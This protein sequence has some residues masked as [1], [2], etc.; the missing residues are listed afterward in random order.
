MHALEIK[1]VTKQYDGFCLDS[2]NLC[3]PRGCIMGLIGEN[4]PRYEQ[5]TLSIT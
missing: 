5:K 4:V 1:N 3:L 2:V